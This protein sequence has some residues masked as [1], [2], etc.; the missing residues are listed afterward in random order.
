M[1][2]DAGLAEVARPPRRGDGLV[3]AV[4]VGSLGLR[5]PLRAAP[6]RAGLDVAV[7]RLR[8][9]APPRRLVKPVAGVATGLAVDPGEVSGSP[10][11]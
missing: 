6:Q 5:T 1:A 11:L 9:E 2:D 4:E 8:P 7:A 10:A 3:K